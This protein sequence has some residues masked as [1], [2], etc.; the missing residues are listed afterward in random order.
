M[1]DLVRD[2]L[3]TEGWRSF[4]I[5]KKKDREPSC[6]ISPDGKWY[7]VPVAFHG[8]FAWHVVKDLKS[9]SDEDLLKYDIIGKAGDILVREFKWIMIEDDYFGCGTIVR[10]YQNMSEAQYK[11]MKEFFGN[12]PLFRGWTVRAMWL[13]KEEMKE[14]GKE[15]ERGIKDGYNR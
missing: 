10:G 6:W 14:E 8:T 4:E 15:D 9:I 2:Q 11:V 5:K 13:A 1:G 7:N 3:E 12:K